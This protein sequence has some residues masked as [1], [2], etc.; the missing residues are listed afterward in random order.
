MVEKRAGIDEI[1]SSK[2]TEQIN[3]T[4]NRF[5][6]KIDGIDK[7]LARLTKIKKKKKK[8]Q[9]TNTGNKTEGISTDRRTI[10]EIKSAVNHF[11]LINSKPQ[12]KPTD[13]LKTTDYQTQ[14][15]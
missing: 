4:K 13:P 2:T 1:E 12:K 14:S 8:T 5:F 6:E 10:K 7:L 9:I 15:R 11:T 3:K